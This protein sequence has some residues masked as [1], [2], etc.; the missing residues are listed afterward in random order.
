MG[1]SALGKINLGVPAYVTAFTNAS[2][3][4]GV[5]TVNH[6]LNAQYVS[7]TVTNDSDNIIIP[8]DVTMTSTTVATIDLTSYGTIAGTWR[9]TVL[10]SGTTSSGAA[11]NLAL[12]G[13]TTDDIAVYN[14]TAWVAQAPA[15]TSFVGFKAY[16]A[17]NWTIPDNAINVLPFNA[18]NFDIGSN[19]D[20]GTGL[21]TAPQNGYYRLNTRTFWT[22]VPS[23]A[24]NIRTYI[25]GGPNQNYDTFY[26]DEIGGG[27]TGAVTRYSAGVTAIFYMTTG[28][29]ANVSVQLLTGTTGTV[30]IDD[31]TSSS[32][33]NFFE[34]YLIGT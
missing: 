6:G 16:R 22:T 17:G 4:A 21:F 2:L 11:S 33:G 7:V 32:N 25:V 26:L 30:A 27:I 19:F 20:T 23:N 3:T 12:A 1:Q 10:N 34:G 9:V 24:G 18:E 8:D 14:G 31:G 28:Q 15:A 5:L 13:Q 29:T